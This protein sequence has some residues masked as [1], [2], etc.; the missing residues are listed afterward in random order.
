MNFLS[1]LNKADLSLTCCCCCWV[2]AQ[3]A[4]SP[5]PVISDLRKKKRAL[6]STSAHTPKY[7]HKGWCRRHIKSPE[8]HFLMLFFLYFFIWSYGKGF[9]SNER[10][11]VNCTVLC[12]SCVSLRTLATLLLFYLLIHACQNSEDIRSVCV[13]GRARVYGECIVKSWIL[14]DCG[15]MM[16]RVRGPCVYA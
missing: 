15:H 2:A 12:C 6:A 3:Q 14:S 9:V 4:T 16:M 8:H 7:I 10:A 13:Q 1:I 5:L 11:L